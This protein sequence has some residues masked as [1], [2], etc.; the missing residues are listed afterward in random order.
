MLDVI[1]NF[2]DN[3]HHISAPKFKPIKEA[4]KDEPPVPLVE[5]DDFVLIDH[6]GLSVKLGLTQTKTNTLIRELL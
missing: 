4:L 2:R 1:I 5:P 3:W 6:K